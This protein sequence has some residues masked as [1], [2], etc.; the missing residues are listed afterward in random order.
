MQVSVTFRHM[1]PSQPLKEYATNKIKRVATKYFRAEQLEASVVL[2]A[3]KF[4]HI[5][6]ISINHKGLRA[7]VEERTEE[8]YSSIDLAMDKIESRI[9]RHKDKL[10][11]HKAPAT[12]DWAA[13][14]EPIEEPDEVVDPVS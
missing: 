9:R 10:R 2:S 11:D 6:A 14:D 13:D 7:T 4:W 5:A 1:P 8:M 12:G 3:E